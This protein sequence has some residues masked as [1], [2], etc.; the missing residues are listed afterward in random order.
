MEYRYGSHTVFQ[1]EHHFVWVTKYRTQSADGRRCRESARLGA[2]NLWSVWGQNSK[3]GC[4]QGSRAYSGELS[5]DYGAKRDHEA[6]QGADVEQ[7]AW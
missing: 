5:A 6:D 3:M 4:E 2:G 7:I 1:I